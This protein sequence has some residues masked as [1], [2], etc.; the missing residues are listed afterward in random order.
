[1]TKAAHGGAAPR[2]PHC[3]GMVQARFNEGIT[4]TLACG[5]P[6]RADQAGREGWRISTMC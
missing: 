6:R 3:T 2:Q 5:L 4:N 1:M